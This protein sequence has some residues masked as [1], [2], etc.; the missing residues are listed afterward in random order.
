MPTLA[1]RTRVQL[2]QAV[3]FNVA[4]N[5]FYVGATTSAGGD[6]T[7]VID[8]RLRGGNDALNGRWVRFTS[9]TLN[10]EV[11]RADDYVQSSTDITVAPAYTL[12]VPSG[13]SYELWP[14][15]FQPARVDEFTSQA[16]LDT[17]GGAY[18]P[19]ESLALHTGGGRSPS[20]SSVSSGIPRTGGFSRFDV[21]SG[22][23]AIEQVYHRDSVA[24]QVLHDCERVFDEQVDSGLTAALDDEIK[25]RGSN[26]L[27][28]TVAAG[29]A[30]SAKVT[31]SITS[32]DIS[33]KTHIEFWCRSTFAALAAGI[34][35]LLDDTAACASPVETLAL[36]A[37]VADTDT[38][39]RIALANPQSDTA[40]ISVGVRFTTDNGAQ[41][42]WIDD[43]QA[44]ND[45]TAIWER[46]SRRGWSLEK[47]TGDL[48]LS[49]EARVDL[50]YAL[51]KLEQ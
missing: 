2:R 13:A 12:T 47:G 29:A 28:V 49:E 3:G 7:S 36:P 20:A 5:D 6:T 50:G 17:Y 4:G 8:N 44:V 16:I 14:A 33:G 37:L 39:V 43:I 21:P 32:I 11:S 45:N 1:G 30:A 27:K 38:F 40:I 9:G 10:G 22:I 42:F 15:E 25:W 26:S 23:K 34:H 18:D 51:L 31:D 46:V 24:S 35:L 19:V 41:T 48:L